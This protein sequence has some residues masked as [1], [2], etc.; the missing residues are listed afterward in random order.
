M[1]Q[2]YLSLKLSSTHQFIPIEKV[3]KRCGVYIFYHNQIP[4]YVGK[5]SNLKNRLQ[6]YL[7]I[8]DFKTEALHRDAD[9]LKLIKLRS[10]IEALIVE[11]RLIKSL[12]PK[13]KILWRDDKSYFYVYFTRSTGSGQAKEL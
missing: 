5:A 11:S 4:L 9:R 3:P 6:S 13:L 12:K 1:S 7:K 8:T 10:N 2:E